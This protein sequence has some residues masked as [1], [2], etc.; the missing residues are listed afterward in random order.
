VGAARGVLTLERLLTTAKDA[1]RLQRRELPL[2]TLVLRTALELLDE[3]PF[4]ERLL[5]VARRAA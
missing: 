1:E 2:P 4:L 5:S 3:Q